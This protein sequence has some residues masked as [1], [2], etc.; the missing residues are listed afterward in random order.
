MLL[1]VMLLLQ[2]LNFAPVLVLGPVAEQM[3]LNTVK[4]VTK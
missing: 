2:L 4:D 1:S 3:T